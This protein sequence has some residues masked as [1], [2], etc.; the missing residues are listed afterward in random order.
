M[1]TRDHEVFPV[2]EATHPQED[3]IPQGPQGIHNGV[4]TSNRLPC[5]KPPPVAGCMYLCTILLNLSLPQFPQMENG[6]SNSTFR[7]VSSNDNQCISV[8]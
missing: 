2:F 4:G 3:I 8:G 5:F 7:T 1:S 6:G